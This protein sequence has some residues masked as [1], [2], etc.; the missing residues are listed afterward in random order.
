LSEPN[1]AYRRPDQPIA[2]LIRQFRKFSGRAGSAGTMAASAQNHAGEW[3][4][5]ARSSKRRRAGLA[6]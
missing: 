1:S 6:G 3:P 2:I 4:E 5:A